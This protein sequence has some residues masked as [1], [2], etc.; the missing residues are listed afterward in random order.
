MNGIL[1][2]HK[3]KGLTSHDCVMRVRKL[4]HIK[5][6]GHTGTL[7]PEVEGVLPICIGE[8]TKIIPYVLHL[9]K[10]Y[11]ADVALGKATTTEDKEG[12]VIEQ[13]EVSSP[14]T[15]EE[16]EKVLQKFKGDIIQ[17]P[18]MYSAV[19]VKGKRLYEYA[20]AGINVER[21]QRN[22]TI[23]QIERKRLNDY[24]IND[25]FRIKVTCS[26]GTYIRTLCVD[27]G[28]KL[29]YP[30]H[31]AYLKRIESDSFHIDD[32]YTFDELEKAVDENRLEDILLP[33]DRGLNHLDT[34]QVDE[35]TKAKILQGQKFPLPSQKFKTESFK[36]MHHNELLAIYKLHKNEEIKPERVFNIYKNVGE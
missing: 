1:P 21:P 30:A 9:K 7:D 34:M 32:T 35:K 33:V 4:L 24:L 29:G 8:A 20:R 6:V 27:I 10:V 17:I 36:V 31:M 15:D 23:F 18:P 26:K 22:V 25:K 14:P 16:I 13:K 5:K 3:P 12:D 2:L 19:K 28:K 11:I